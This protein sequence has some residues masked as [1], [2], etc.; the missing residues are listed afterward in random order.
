MGA[1]HDVLGQTKEVIQMSTLD[2][3]EKKLHEF[4][5]MIFKQLADRDRMEISDDF[6]YTNGGRAKATKA[7]RENVENLTDNLRS[8]R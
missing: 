4:I 3:R 6:Y 2:L 8:I 7:I 1:E 5:T